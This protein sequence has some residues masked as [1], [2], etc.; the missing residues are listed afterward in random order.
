MGEIEGL[1]CRSRTERERKLGNKVKD[2][3]LALIHLM[4]SYVC[5][6]KESVC[7]VLITTWPLNHFSV[8]CKN[9]LHSVDTNISS[10]SDKQQLNYFHNSITYSVST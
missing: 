9:I 4:V 3:L 7:L 2:A 10:L 1:S 5:L 8:I 6:P